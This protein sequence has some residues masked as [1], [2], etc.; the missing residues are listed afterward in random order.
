[1]NLAEAEEAAE[2]DSAVIVEEGEEDVEVDVEVSVIEEEEADS[3]DEEVVEVDLMTVVAAEEEVH[4]EGESSESVLLLLHANT[5]TI[6]I[7]EHELEESFQL[8]ARR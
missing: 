5:R 7:V 1:M 2:V 4:L 6:M 3:V 8:K